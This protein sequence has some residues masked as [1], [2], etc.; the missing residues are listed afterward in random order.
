MAEIII[1]PN[2]LGANI[3]E[4]AGLV[5]RQ[6]EQDVIMTQ[7]AFSMSQ[8]TLTKV[9]AAY[10]TN[11][12]SKKVGSRYY[13]IPRKGNPFIS[14]P[15]QTVVSGVGTTT[16]S[17]QFADTTFNGIA[18]N[19][20]VTDPATGTLATV[21]SIG[22]G[23]AILQ[24]SDNANGATTFTTA[25]FASGNL[26]SPR[27]VVNNNQI[28]KVSNSS[29]IVPSLDGYP[30]GVW[31]GDCEI[32]LDDTK[33]KTYI[34]NVNG[35]NYYALIKQQ[36]MINEVYTRYNAY[37]YGDY[38][39]IRS[40]TSPRSPSL[41]N[42][43]KTFAPQNIRPKSQPKISLSELESII[44]EWARNGS[45]RSNKVFCFAGYD[46]LQNVYEILRFYGTTAGTTN[47][48]GTDAINGLDVR[49]YEAFGLKIYFILDMFLENQKVWGGTGRSNS[50]IW[51][52]SS[53]VMLENGDTMAPV[54][55]VHNAYDGFHAWNVN[56]GFDI[57]GNPVQEGATSQTSASSHI[58]FEKTMIIG[59]PNASLFHF[60]A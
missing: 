4:K 44:K 37:Y 12:T 20:L 11:M 13:E 38:Q 59:N 8:S 5:P 33:R 42:Q 47:V 32:F 34:T 24:Y 51:I 1:N 30:I 58:Y 15:V 21:V 28:R 35:T 45:L 18:P 27:G 49:Y 50:A 25:D 41:I 43:I 22:Q 46:Y 29:Y 9:M 60:Y 55:N 17:I 56:G 16:L 10:G 48:I 31:S 39:G 36:E 26:V 7:P 52:D 2:E 53:P 3:F 57:N 19:T 6:V 14:Q 40:D 23:T 54:Y